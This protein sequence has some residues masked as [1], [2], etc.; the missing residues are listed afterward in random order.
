MGNHDGKYIFLIYQEKYSRE[1]LI[2]RKG[3]FSQISFRIK[4][5]VFINIFNF[6]YF[7]NLFRVK[8]PAN[9][10]KMRYNARHAVRRYLYLLQAV[11]TKKNISRPL[12]RIF[13]KY[14]ESILPV[15]FGDIRALL[16]R[17]RLLHLRP[18]NV[19]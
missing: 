3:S 18:T 8:N 12:K 4:H 13:R 19:Q 10:I 17:V 14:R 6:N 16:K 5:Q 11:F 1:F 15:S 9:F 2:S 7:Q